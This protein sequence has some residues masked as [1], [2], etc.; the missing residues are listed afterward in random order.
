MFKGGGG[1]SAHCYQ[2]HLCFNHKRC[3]GT[4]IISDLSPGAAFWYAHAEWEY[5]H[6]HEN[7]KRKYPVP[8]VSIVSTPDIYSW[9]ISHSSEDDNTN[10]ARS[11][12]T[13]ATMTSGDV[14]EA[15]VL[16]HSWHWITSNTLM[17]LHSA[18]N[19]CVCL[20]RIWVTALHA[21]RSCQCQ[22]QRQ[23]KRRRDHHHRRTKSTDSFSQIVDWWISIC[24]VLLPECIAGLLRSLLF[25]NLAYFEFRL[26]P[27]SFFRLLLSLPL[28]L[29]MNEKTSHLVITTTSHDH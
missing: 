16:A 2:S 29:G 9:L 26:F 19:A 14:N 17:L 20:H 25:A 8:S 12:S 18:I 3:V 15:V 10:T 5:Q 27:Y 24:T 7:G 28:L 22:R 13:V 1:P 21:V 11:G 6:F 4:A 23:W